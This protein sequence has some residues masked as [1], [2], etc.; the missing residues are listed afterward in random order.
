MPVF[1]RG[2]RALRIGVA[3]IAV[4]ARGGCAGKARPALTP[5]VFVAV[6]PFVAAEVIAEV[7]DFAV[8][9]GGEAT[10][11]FRASSERRSPTT[12]VTSRASWSFR[13]STARSVWC[14]RTK[15]VAL[16]AA[17]NTTC[18]FTRAGRC[19]RAGDDYCLARGGIRPSVCWS[20]CPMKTF[21]LRARHG[22]RRPK[23]PKRQPRW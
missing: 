18:S 20:W 7:K 14:G 15:T 19:K 6:A 9:L 8:T 5:G 23:W 2:I 16:L 1:A 3:C 17:T 11:N 12:A 22:R 21:T 10:G 13:R 4:A